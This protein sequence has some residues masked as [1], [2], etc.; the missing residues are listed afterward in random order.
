VWT[1]P[2]R[3]QRWHGWRWDDPPGS[4]PRAPGP[5]RSGGNEAGKQVL[6]ARELPP[7]GKEPSRSGRSHARCVTHQQTHLRLEVCCVASGRWLRRSQQFE[8]PRQDA[9]GRATPR[10]RAVPPRPA[11]KAPGWSCTSGHRSSKPEARCCG[12]DAV[13]AVARRCRG[14]HPPAGSRPALKRVVGPQEP[15][16]SASRRV[17]DGRRERRQHSRVAT[18][19]RHFDGGSVTEPKPA[20]SA[21]DCHCNWQCQGFAPSASFTRIRFGAHRAHHNTT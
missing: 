17:C 16:T 4:R 2:C 11:P 14:Q 18:G 8:P 7:S 12:A 19:A 9:A 15:A 21:S 5:H 6:E 13:V 3:L 10:A 20:S 1:A